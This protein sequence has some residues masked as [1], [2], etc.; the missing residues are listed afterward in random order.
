MGSLT[1]FATIELQ[2][3]LRTFDILGL[4]LILLWG[5]SPLGGQA[6][7]R[8]LEIGT[9]PSSSPH[10]ISYLDSDSG[11]ILGQGADIMLTLGFY[12]NALYLSALFTPP[13]G[14]A[15]AVD[16]WSNVKIPKIETLESTQTSDVDG[17]YAVPHENTS[18]SSL[19]GL[20]V[21]GIEK[22][23]SYDFL[24]ESHYMVLDCPTVAD[25]TLV[26]VTSQG[27]FSIQFILE[28]S[29][30]ILLY[31][32]QTSYPSVKPW[33]VNFSA[34][35][36]L[37]TDNG[38]TANCTLTRSSV[39]SNITCDHGSCSV[40]QIRRSEFDQRPA[41]YVP[42]YY[43]VAKEG[44]E[45]YWPK[46]GGSSEHSGESTPTEYFIADPTMNSLS[47]SIETWG[48][49]L[50]GLSAELFSERLSLL[51][52]TF[53]QCSLA[54]WYQTG[55]F[56][57][58]ASSLN[59]NNP[60]LSSWVH[61]NTTTTAVTTLTEIYICNKIWAAILFVASSVLLLCGLCG[62][63][64]K[65]MTHGPNILGYVSTM[66]RDNPYIDLPSGGCTLD[67]LERAR[68]LKDLKVKMQDVA[69]ED[70]VG[71]IAFGSAEAFGTGKL[72]PGRLYA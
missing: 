8:L 2:F 47:T 27:G 3:L 26:N 23:G 53:W 43:G 13:T 25:F 72:L 17:W 34:A 12:I 7:L 59:Y 50:K 1:I 39:E 42:L 19:V 4:G 62:A 45:D 71:H 41:G 11:S 14:Q 44:V 56:P 29:T 66:T 18:Y 20:P 15:S 57:S 6:S 35:S 54:P 64:V 31:H 10:N 60:D 48:V 46:S 21:D 63:V 36:Y 51:L 22:S 16:I 52:N 67:G 68:L 37:E 55:N 69:S 5:L 70:A 58:N 24:L 28:N 40:T 38:F 9:Q 65:H 30:Q 32:N 61:F 33:G 49:S